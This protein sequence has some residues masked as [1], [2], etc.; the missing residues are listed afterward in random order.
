MVW[1][2]TL[3]SPVGVLWTNGAEA[4]CPADGDQSARARIKAKHRA[5]EDVG[6]VLVIRMVSD[7][8]VTGHACRSVGV[9]VLVVIWPS[10]FTVGARNTKRPVVEHRHGSL[11]VG[12][13]KRRAIVG[14]I[15]NAK[16]AAKVEERAVQGWR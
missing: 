3:G 6:A 7:H 13:G 10:W 11:I 9:A 2:S 5:G 15:H 1:K 14:A 4:V 16:M 8:T 12:R